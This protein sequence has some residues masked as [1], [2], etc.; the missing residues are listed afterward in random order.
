MVAQRDI[1]K[2]RV[3]RK[4]RGFLEA[5]LLLAKAEGWNVLKGG[6]TVMNTA[7]EISILRAKRNVGKGEKGSRNQEEKRLDLMF[8]SQ[9]ET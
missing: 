1:M 7:Q 8:L 6:K 2:S 3:K 4:M 5:G 9:R